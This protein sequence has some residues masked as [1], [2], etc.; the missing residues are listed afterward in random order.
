M[1]ET[2]TSIDRAAIALMTDAGVCALPTETVYG[3][4][5]RAGDRA[6]VRRVFE[7][8][9]RP[10]FD[11]LIVHVEFPDNAAF[12]YAGGV[13]GGLVQR[14]GEAFWPGPLTIVAPKAE[15][16][17]DAVTGGLPT[18]GVRVPDH[19]LC[20]AVLGEVGPVAMPSAN[21][22]GM[23]SPTTAQH[24]A[25][26]FADDELLILDG[27]PCRAGIESTVVRIEANEEAGANAG[28]GAGSDAGERVV[29]LR[30][31]AVTV[32]MLERVAGAGKVRIAAR[33]DRGAS[34]GS[35]ERHYGLSV[36]LVI[37]E[38]AKNAAERARV[39]LGFAGG[40][41]VNELCLDADPIAAARG[42]YAS[43]REAAG[44]AD[45]VF[46]IRTGEML[47]DA[48]WWAAI[49]DRLERAA[50]RVSTGG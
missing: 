9:G 19:G 8:K 38:G 23:V 49:W 44:N 31:G 26:A 16:V 50:A 25:Q 6:A 1:P 37:V 20:R 48:G 10:S 7:I 36:P 34:P 47:D 21:K 18:V 32:P 42:L 5:A 2:T 27:G 35:T 33:D 45:G 12:V 40:A 29:V 28:A 4:G 3:L 39:A 17:S 13:W 11:P 30:P 41:S 14:L 24:V 46:V 22:F 43:M 15:W